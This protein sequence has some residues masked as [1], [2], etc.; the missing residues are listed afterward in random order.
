MSNER[1][2]PAKLEEI[3]NRG[4]LDE[5]RGEFVPEHLLFE[6]QLWVEK[7]RRQQIELV[8]HLRLHPNHL[9]LFK[10]ICACISLL[11]NMEEE[12]NYGNFPEYRE[13]EAVEHPNRLKAIRG[14]AEELECLSQLKEIIS[15]IFL[16]HPEWFFAVNWQ[17]SKQLMETHYLGL[18]KGDFTFM[19]PMLKKLGL[20]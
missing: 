8:N 6:K 18:E 3:I 19:K 17:C 16:A 14:L 11:N 7:R 5:Y 20:L 9:E 4:Y 1:H 15:M 10:M 2:E 12:R 13:W